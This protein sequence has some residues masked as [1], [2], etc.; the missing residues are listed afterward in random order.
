MTVSNTI[1]TDAASRN[2]YSL[3]QTSAH[4]LVTNWPIGEDS[5]M[6]EATSKLP[7]LV[8]SRLPAGFHCDTTDDICPPP[9]NSGHSTKCRARDVIL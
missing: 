3:I 8:Q 7:T 5:L 9:V 6:N 4:E 1:A 2:E